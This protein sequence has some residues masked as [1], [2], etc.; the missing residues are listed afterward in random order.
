MKQF[1]LW[2]ALALI[3]LHCPCL[4]AQDTLLEADFTQGIPDSFTVTNL[5][6]SVTAEEGK[7]VLLSDNQG[8]A[9]IKM[10]R[11]AAPALTLNESA[12]AYFTLTVNR[13]V[14][15]KEFGMVADVDTAIFSISEGE[16]KVA[17][18]SVYTVAEGTEYSIAVGFAKQ[19]TVIAVNG[20]I[21]FSGEIPKVSPGGKVLY[22]K[23]LTR[24]ANDTSRMEI[25]ALLICAGA[26]YAPSANVENGGALIPQEGQALEIA[27][28]TPLL[29]APSAALEKNGE[30]QQT[31]LQ[32][33]AGKLSVTP[34]AGWEPLQSYRLTLNH[35]INGAGEAQTDY[36]LAFSTLPAGY[37]PPV[38]SLSGVEPN[39]RSGA[40]VTIEVQVQSTGEI[41]KTELLLDGETVQR[42][43]GVK[44]FIQR[45]YAAGT[46][47][48]AVRVYDGISWTKSAE[49]PI[50]VIENTP[51]EITF[52]D[53]PE[54]GSVPENSLENIRVQIT[55]DTGIS[56]A[57]LKLNG[58]P[59][60]DYEIQGDIYCFAAKAALLGDVR[61]TAEAVDLDGAW[62]G[63]E[64][65]L[66]VSGDTV[67]SAIAALDYEGEYVNP[68]QLFCYLQGKYIGETKILEDK[69]DP[70]KNPTTAY[71]ITKPAGTTGAA[72]YAGAGVGDAG[73]FRL[74]C[75][76]YLENMTNF[77]WMVR[78]SGSE[79]YKN[80]QVGG[81][82]MNLYDGAA[83]SS[84]VT[85]ETG[86]WY[87]FVFTCD[88]K[89]SKYRFTMDGEE[90]TMPEGNRMVGLLQ[91][92][93][94]SDIR[95]NLDM[96]DDH[97]LAFDNWKF[98][99]LQQPAVIENITL[100]QENQILIRVS[101]GTKSI[102]KNMAE[103]LSGVWLA[104]EGRKNAVT[105]A[106][107]DEETDQIRLT[108]QSPLYTAAEY[109]LECDTGLLDIHNTLRRQ[110][111]TVKW[112]ETPAAEF[113]I[114]D[115]EWLREAGG[116][117]ARAVVQNLGAEQKSA[118]MVMVFLDQEGAVT[119]LYSSR[120]VSVAQGT[121][122]VEIPPK[123]LAGG[124]AE[125]FFLNGWEDY[126]GIKSVTYQLN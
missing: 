74:S 55:D 29:C 25:G 19:K 27:F 111:T 15:E 79:F 16:M 89:E 112:F 54:G 80:V 99:K 37:E 1:T 23:N 52:L 100:L 97:A 119:G 22:F 39:C 126:L 105:A 95:I 70:L 14:G 125:V 43:D 83:I 21:V 24:T 66:S 118:V 10:S 87:H 90:L 36:Q 50:E 38:V 58:S 53:F 77:N 96:A 120:V 12:V 113:D 114:L 57:V 44:S 17:G 4:A 67:P 47:R 94:I 13:S 51:P 85:L 49:Y 86:R 69:V 9:G 109:R 42:A 65:R 107:Y 117:G 71:Q 60:T 33:R 124:R 6:G 31:A 116:V 45:M 35:L 28:G 93:I 76:M 2:M 61:V 104:C 84:S 102:A 110:M 123:Y 108:A 115:F 30:P 7:A 122:T 73:V 59:V 81:G 121:E 18:Q 3:L 72:A 8:G 98:E 20:E 62:N 56:E 82:K 88:T 32:W 64:A 101:E 103:H 26:S 68:P 63:K 75:D 34:L 46:H 48:I 106:V 78:G 92:P 5:G 91:S 40:E 11:M 41:L